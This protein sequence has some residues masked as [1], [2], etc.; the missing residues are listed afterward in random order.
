MP[1]QSRLTA[2]A[3]LDLRSEL[4]KRLVI[5]GVNLFSLR[6]A[7][8]EFRANSNLLLQSSFV[9]VEHSFKKTLMNRLFGAFAKLQETTISFGLSIRCLS[10]RVY[11]CNSPPEGFSQSLVS[12]FLLKLVSTLRF[13]LKMGK[14][15]RRFYMGAD[16]S[17]ARPG[18]KQATAT[19]DFESHISYLLS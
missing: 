2:S 6:H 19:K 11:Q 9:F 16:K 14:N 10:V 13:W 5:I 15:N 7:F 4:Q 3:T 18:S 1:S 8:Q 12:V 17:L